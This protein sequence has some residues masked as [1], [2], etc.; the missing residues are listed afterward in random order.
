MKPQQPL[1]YAN[2]AKSCEINREMRMSVKLAAL[3]LRALF[4]LHKEEQNEKI[5]Y[6]RICYG[7]PS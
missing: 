4:Y 3:S 2:G 5:I 6:F 1:L 7:R